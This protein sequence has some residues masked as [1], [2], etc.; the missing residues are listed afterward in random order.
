MKA[1]QIVQQF[2]DA[3][4][5]GDATQL[6][7]VLPDKFTMIGPTPEPVGKAGLID[8]QQ[9]LVGAMPDW[10]FNLDDAYEHGNQ[11]AG[12]LHITGTHSRELRLPFLGL[13]P[14]PASGPIKRHAPAMDNP[15]RTSTSN[16]LS[17]RTSPA[18]F[19]REAEPK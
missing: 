15:A 7:S 1:M 17:I 14:I 19:R 2:L 11:V 16:P 5:S 4:E 10:K 9:A 18:T 13:E 3:I 12:V 8:V 6:A